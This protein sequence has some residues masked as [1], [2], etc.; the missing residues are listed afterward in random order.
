[1]G[2]EGGLDEVRD[3]HGCFGC[4]RLNPH[5]LRLRFAAMADGSGVWAAFTPRPE[6]EGY[7]GMV[8]GGIV[9]T[10]LD[11]AMAWA[12]STRGIW[13]VTAKIEVRFRR[14]VAIGSPLRAL[15]RLAADRGRLIE[16]AGEV[17]RDVDG[18]L[19]AEATATFARVSAEQE[20][21]WRERYLAVGGR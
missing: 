15:G 18:E 5:G 14:P 7:G 1:M 16:T 20:R 6:D 17:R 4:G 8:H 21:V 2:F 9:T 12:I 13:A 11:E 3:D 10:L 19:L